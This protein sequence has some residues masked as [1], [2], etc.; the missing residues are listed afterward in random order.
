MMKIYE[1]NAIKGDKIVEHLKKVEMR[2][3]KK[4][5]FG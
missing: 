1:K 2:G 5:A 3:R 4:V